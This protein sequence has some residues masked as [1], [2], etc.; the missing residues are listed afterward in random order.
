MQL[1]ID[2]AGP[3]VECGRSHGGSGGGSDGHVWFRAEHGPGVLVH[4]V[5]RVRFVHVGYGHVSMADAVAVDVQDAR[6]VVVW[7]GRA[8]GSAGFAHR[9]AWSGFWSAGVRGCLMFLRGR[10]SVVQAWSSPPHK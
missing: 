8:A 7:G 9:G 2:G 3:V 5:Q 1:K 10:H 4:F 6:G